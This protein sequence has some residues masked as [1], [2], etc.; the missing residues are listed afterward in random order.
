LFVGAGICGP[1]NLNQGSDGSINASKALTWAPPSTT[2]YVSG[3]TTTIDWSLSNVTVITMASGNTTLGVPSNP[4]GSGPYRIIWIQD[5]SC[6]TVAYN[7]IFKGGVAPDCTSGATTLQDFTWD[8]ASYQSAVA[9]VPSSLWHGTEYPPVAFSNFPSC[10]SSYDGTIGTVTDSTTTEQGAVVAGSG[11]NHVSIYCNGTNWI[12]LSGSA[13]TVITTGTSAVLSTAFTVNQEA[14][15][16]AGVTYT[17]PTAASGLQRCIDNGWNG[18]A[19]DTGVLTFSTS[20]S[21]QFMVFTDGTLTATGGN[22]TSG[23]AARDGACVYGI[24]STHWMFLPHSGT[25]TKH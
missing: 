18:S 9:S 8:G 16:G 5:T 7:A 13:V 20:A 22:V 19:A 10:S 12:V 1:A 15:A 6:R 4:H 2:T 25:W 21:G 14:T 17:L 23:G 3:G 11:T 24:D